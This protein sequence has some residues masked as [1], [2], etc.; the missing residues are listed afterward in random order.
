MFKYLDLTKVSNISSSFE[1]LEWLAQ[2]QNTIG[3]PL[4]QKWNHSK[5]KKL[6]V[7]TYSEGVTAFVKGYNQGCADPGKSYGSGSFLR[8]FYG[9]GSDQFQKNVMGVITF[10]ERG[11]AFGT[12]RTFVASDRQGLTKHFLPSCKY[13]FLQFF[14]DF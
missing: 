10:R 1:G 7:Y 14:R 8:N 13:F 3:N 6:I 5:M 9:S 12:R 11:D 4:P 2:T